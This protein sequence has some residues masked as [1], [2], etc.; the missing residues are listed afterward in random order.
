MSKFKWKLYYTE[1][2]RV[3]LYT[4]E[5]YSGWE[6]LEAMDEAK[7]WCRRN[8]IFHWSELETIRFTRDK[9]V[10]AFLLRWS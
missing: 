1:P 9:D 7:R 10:T 5:Q 4:D 3:M 8:S 6:W 2:R